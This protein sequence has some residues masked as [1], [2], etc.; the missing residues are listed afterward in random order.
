MCLVV[1]FV[2]LS[3]VLVFL[4]SRV[5]LPPAGHEYKT[6]AKL[7]IYILVTHYDDE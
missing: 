3:F 5:Y 1:F 4:V 6:E 7:L 2:I